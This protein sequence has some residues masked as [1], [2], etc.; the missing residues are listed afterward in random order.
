MF[1]PM[2]QVSSVVLSSALCFG[3][4]IASAP[5]TTSSS[6]QPVQ[7]PATPAA[8]A[9]AQPPPAAANTTRNPVKATAESQ[10]KAKKTY[11][12]DCEMCHASNGSGKTDLAKDMQLTLTDLSNPKTLAGKSDGDIF[13]IIRKGKDKMPP[14]EAARAKDDDIWNLVIYVRNLAKGNTIVASATNR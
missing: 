8:P 4:A 11:G 5:T 3:V 9:P 13:D 1:R 12:F 7:E 10:A 6:G 14:E 2:L